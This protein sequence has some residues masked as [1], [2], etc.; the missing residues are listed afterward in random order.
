MGLHCTIS[1]SHHLEMFIEFIGPFKKSKLESSIY[2]R[3]ASWPVP[4]IFQGGGTELKKYR[5]G[6]VRG[7][8]TVLI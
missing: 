1:V 5:K 8:K 7:K 4:R 6:G 2:S 3:V